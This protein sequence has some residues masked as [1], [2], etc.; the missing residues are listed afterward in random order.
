MLLT[1]FEGYPKDISPAKLYEL[2][3]E[4]LV[5]KNENVGKRTYITTPITSGGAIHLTDQGGEKLPIDQVIKENASFS[6]ILLEF[7]ANTGAFANDEL[8]TLPSLLESMNLGETEEKQRWKER[9]Y[10]AFWIAVFSGMKPNLVEEYWQHVIGSN[11]D[12]QAF[13]DRDSSSQARSKRIHEYKLL[14]KLSLDFIKPNISSCSLADRLL[15]FPDSSTSL[16]STLEQ[17]VASQLGI[18]LQEVSINPLMIGELDNEL[19]NNRVLLT[20]AKL[21]KL[22]GSGLSNSTSVAVLNCLSTNINYNT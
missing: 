19:K 16:G 6:L 1:K 3:H 2:M 8:I 13:N 21:G 15:K 4:S 11:I 12:W 20:L 22:S 14:E 18:E 5:G 17:R 9:E 7:L 10:L